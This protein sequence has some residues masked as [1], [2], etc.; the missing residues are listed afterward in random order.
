M[1][2]GFLV[3]DKP[4]G[5]TS[6]DLVGILRSVTGVKRVGHTG[7]LDPFATG[8]LPLALGPATRFIQFLDEGEKVYEATLRFGADT[9][10]LDLE[11]EVV[12]EA[13]PP[14]LSL[15]ERVV[16]DRI[17][18]QL[19]RPPAYSAVKVDGKALY[20][21]AREGQARLAEPRPIHVHE[22]RVVSADSRE[23]SFMCRVS[24]G[25]Y[26]RVLAEEIARALG[27]A[28]HLVQLRRTRSG[29][30]SIEDA[31]SMDELAQAACGRADWTLAFARE[32]DRRLPR[33]A[34]DEVQASLEPCLVSLYEATAHLPSVEVQ[35]PGPVLHGRMPECELDEGARFR[36]LHGR[37]L[38]AVAERRDGRS[39]ALRV[40]ASA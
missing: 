10:T 31:L 15:L 36:V 21:Y 32:R 39:R 38:L 12:R 22:L 9:D 40:L 6:H 8:V 28:G 18:S 35:E 34:R 5:R 7:T 33:R 23:M 26:I 2:P 17:G 30:F 14:D 29:P 13:G 3:L 37:Q 4:A 24:R 27:S 19:Q 1:R 16:A 11:G 20:K 25:T